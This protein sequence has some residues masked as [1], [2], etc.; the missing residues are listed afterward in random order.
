MPK[1]ISVIVPIFNEEKNIPLLYSELRHVFENLKEKYD[2]EFI[3]I[4]DGSRD[5]SIRILN[6]L[7]ENDQDVKVL[8]FSRNFGKEIATTAGI[9]HS[10]GDSVIIMDADL[11]HPPKLI[12]EFLK[13]WEEGA[14]VVIGRREKVQKIDLPKRLG[15]F[16]YYRISNAI[17]EVK[18]KPNETD[19]RLLDRKV[20]DAFNEFSE[21]NRITRGLIDWL[22][23]K[24]AYINFSAPA[25][26]HGKAGYS[27]PKL[28]RLA[29]SS[30][31]SNSLFPLKL[32]GYL[33]LFI[34]LLF[35]ISGLFV[36]IEKYI[37]ADPLELHISGVAV[38][39]I[40]VTFLIGLV[41]SCLGLIALYIG[42]IN[43]EVANRPLYVLRSRKNIEH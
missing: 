39:A 2:Y 30:F 6:E 13:K 33:G 41:L 7:A 22:G 4:D 36:L 5:K 9:N 43:Y 20:V 34:V 38:L 8:G 27:Y 11:Q 23:F 25:R 18:V 12:P 37:L 15:S 26:K 14:E 17:S 29:L 21:K 10:N 3:F 1:L 24:R 32:A 42:N 19:F 35:G 16:F 28:I 40:I 31:I